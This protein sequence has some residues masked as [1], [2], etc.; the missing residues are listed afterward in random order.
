MRFSVGEHMGAPHTRSKSIPQGDP[1]SM[2]MMSYL[3]RPWIKLM[4]SM[5]V[6]PRSLPYD[7][8]LTTTE[9]E[10]AERLSRGVEATEQLLEAMLAHISIPKTSLLGN[11]PRQRAAL[12]VKRWGRKQMP[13][14]VRHDLRDL[15]AHINTIRATR[16]GTMRQ[17]FLAALRVLDRL[18]VM[19]LN[20]SQK[21]TI[22]KGKVYPHGHV[23]GG[24]GPTATEGVQESGGACSRPLHAAA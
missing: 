4:Q 19:P 21:A 10:G 12:R 22:I 3:L 2:M 14:T 1:W 5:D 23:C 18:R 13:L 20:R 17:R 15:G 6:R 11:H 7:M 24:D 8:L 9:D 16:T